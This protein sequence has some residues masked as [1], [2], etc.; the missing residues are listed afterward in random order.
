ME[1]NA[2]ILIIIN[3][4]ASK[5][6]GLK[7][8]SAILSE[9]SKRG[10]AADII[11]TKASGEAIELSY[12]GAVAGYR[13]II[14]AGGDGTVNEVANGIIRS[15]A[16]VEM[17][18]IP[19]GRG[20]DFAWIADIPKDITSAVSLILDTPARTMDV[21]YLEGGDFPTGRYFLNGAGIGFEPS[22]TFKAST[23]KHLN[24]TPSYVIA[25]L[26]CLVHLPVPYSVELTVDGESEKLMTQQISICNG[27]R[28]GSAFIMG[29]DAVINDGK[30]D[31]MYS[32]RKINRRQLMRLVIP[33]LNGTIKKCSVLGFKLG[34]R[35]SVV[36]ERADMVIHVDGEKVS[37]GCSSCTVEIREAALRIHY[38][39]FAC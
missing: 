34:R 9:F 32:K 29:P 31:I 12:Q 6:E 7:K 25:L 21:G 11:E 20:N 27:R 10:I 37:F 3:P 36:S 24:G 16:S 17:G 15:G 19:V 5:G 14:A 35:V 2:D 33:F 22:V 30:L 23:Y 4:N 39:S 26:S 1:R 18:I 13:K 38:R 8:K 28:M